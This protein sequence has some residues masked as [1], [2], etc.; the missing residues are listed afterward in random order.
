MADEDE[1]QIVLPADTSNRNANS[2]QHVL[3]QDEF[4]QQNYDQDANKIAPE[5]HWGCI[6]FK[7]NEFNNNYFSWSNIK[8]NR[9]A[10]G[11]LTE[12]G[13]RLDYKL[14]TYNRS[15]E[16]TL[17]LSPDREEETFFIFARWVKGT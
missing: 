4:S 11:V 13:F 16:Y 1:L 2:A 12:A 5:D 9:F 8:H 15:Q 7:V 3:E 6:F 14:L 10:K 17:K